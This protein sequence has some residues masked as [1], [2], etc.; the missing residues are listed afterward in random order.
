MGFQTM[1]RRGVDVGEGGVPQSPSIPFF[2]KKGSEKSPVKLEDGGGDFP[3]RK[4]QRL[5]YYF[6]KWEGK[7]SFQNTSF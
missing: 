6:G 3:E 1:V 7:N 4:S 5:K 2:R